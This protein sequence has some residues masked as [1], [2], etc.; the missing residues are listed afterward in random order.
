MSGNK[1]EAIRADG[2]VTGANL[3]EIGADP[4][5][6]GY[7]VLCKW[8]D[9]SYTAGWSAMDE[10]DTAYCAMRLDREIKNRLFDGK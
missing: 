2:V 6:D 4:E 8:K 3:V 7:I 9:G 10:R 5:L 1:I